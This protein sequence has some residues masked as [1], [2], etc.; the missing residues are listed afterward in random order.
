[1]AALKAWRAFSA[2]SR[3]AVLAMLH[4]R[5][6]RLALQAFLIRHAAVYGAVTVEL[7]AAMFGLSASAIRSETNALV[8]KGLVNAMW[9]EDATVL[10]FE[11]GLPSRVETLALQLVEK[12]RDLE[13]ANEVVKDELRGERRDVSGRGRHAGTFGLRPAW[14][15]KE[16]RVRGK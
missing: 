13:E 3:A 10:V 7:L 16:N 9:N 14:M 4:E 1:M 2:P 6:Q 11:E 12:L 15:K 5:L 8:V